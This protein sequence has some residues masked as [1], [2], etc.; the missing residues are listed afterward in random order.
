MLVI[1]EETHPETEATVPMTEMPPSISS[2]EV[3][4]RSERWNWSSPFVPG[5]TAFKVVIKIGGC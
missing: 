2:F 4:L 3:T 5:G 1:R